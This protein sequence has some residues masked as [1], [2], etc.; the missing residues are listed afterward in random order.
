[1]KRGRSFAEPSRA[2]AGRQGAGGSSRRPPGP[3]SGEPA[4][5]RQDFDPAR[6]WEHVADWYD[7]LVTDRQHDH[8]GDTI[9]PGL[10]RLLPPRL[11][12]QRW[13]DVACGQGYVAEALAREGAKVVGLDAA[14]SLIEAAR[15][16]T[17]AGPVAS[18]L[19]WVA[20]DARELGTALS[21]AGQPGPYDGAV[22]VMALMN[23]DPLG[24]LL[25]G[26]AEA[27][28][29]GAPFVSVILHSAFRAPG[30][31]SWHWRD[32]IAGGGVQSRQVDSYLT[33][34]CSDI[35]MNPGGVA[36]GARPVT[37]RTHHRPLGAYVAALATAGFAVD[38]LEEWSSSRRS[39][40]GPR[41]SEEN[42]ARAEIPMFAAIRAFRR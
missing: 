27:L 26:L 18:R 14:P 38:A 10:R 34:F 31:S 40:S 11:E 4:R 6:G 17:A 39:T 5:P 2:T 22:C 41:A 29:S 42:R 16:R 21:A 37:T 35:V 7:G 36:S 19:A 20:A 13:L 32:A 25:S 24:S 23:I 8:F 1:M 3:G 28:R 15:R 9:L 30:R 12:G 33:P